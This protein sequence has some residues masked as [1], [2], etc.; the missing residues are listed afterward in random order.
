MRTRGR[1]ARKYRGRGVYSRRGKRGR[2]AGF[3]CVYCLL[4]STTLLYIYGGGGGG[5]MKHG[6]K[7]DGKTTECER[8]WGGKRDS[9]MHTVPYTSL[10]SPLICIRTRG[11]WNM[12][13]SKEGGESKAGWITSL[14]IFMRTRGRTQE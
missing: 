5:G 1:P 2:E 11:R 9:T 10:L 14:L 4:H 8:R 12:H 6:G 13:G 7:R 3:H